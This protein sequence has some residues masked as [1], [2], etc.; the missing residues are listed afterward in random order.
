MTL[1]NYNPNLASSTSPVLT[2][3]P[4]VKRGALAIWPQALDE[5]FGEGTAVS[6]S[7]AA[8]DYAVIE[9]NGPLSFD[10][11][12]FCTYQAICDAVAMACAASAPTILLRINSPGG[13]VSGCFDAARALRAMADASGKKLIAYSDSRMCSA[14]YALGCAA[15]EVYAAESAIV[16]HVGVINIVAD[17]T[18][19]AA[20]SGIRTTVITSGARKA[21][22][23]P[24]VSLSRDAQASMQA[25][26]D[27]LAGQFY[28]LVGEMRGLAEL[29]PIITDAN[30]FIGQQAVSAG[31]VDGIL[32]PAALFAMLA[33]RANPEPATI[34]STNMI[35][36]TRQ[37]L[38]SASEDKDPEMASRAAR[39]ARALAAYDEEDKAEFPEKEEDKAEFPADKDEESKASASEEKPKDEASQAAAAM[40][41]ARKALAAVSA[42]SDAQA[43][44]ALLATRPDLS[45]A[46]R[47]ALAAV[48][49]AALEG[50]LATL[51]AGVPGVL[52]SNS[53]QMVTIAAQTTQSLGNTPPADIARM[54]AAFG[55]TPK[56]PA[57]EHTAHKSIYRVAS[58]GVAPLSK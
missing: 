51:P 30:V 50:V 44:S 43:R 8:P 27:T 12:W 21:D 31:I 14:A 53:A 11:P 32:T 23:H 10:D 28:G 45:A 29:P 36:A 33:D 1:M 58:P 54:D 34:G 20:R 5:L 3:R 24:M 55:L 19:A 42:L 15:H 6:P 41:V 13:D 7:L 9:I 56:L 47:T 18:E 39:A 17:M 46:T 52:T 22:G 38:V 26:V 57:I 16:G 48:P 40:S 25:L 49:V 2:M 37:A 4:P 35:D